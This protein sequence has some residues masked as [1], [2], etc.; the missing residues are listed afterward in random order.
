MGDKKDDEVKLAG[1]RK[2]I[3]EHIA[4]Y[5]TYKIDHEKLFALKTIRNAQQK[6]K[7]IRKGGD[8]GQSLPVFQRKVYHPKG[9]VVVVINL[10]VFFL[11]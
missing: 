2:C 8:Y 7:E 6:I 9:V 5:K 4:K 1:H 10:V 11:S 3:E